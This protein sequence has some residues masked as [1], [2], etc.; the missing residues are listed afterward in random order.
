MNAAPP[1]APIEAWFASRGWTPMD[2]QRQCWQ[3][4]LDGPGS[5][6]LGGSL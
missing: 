1:L 6:S 3:A 4:Y 5:I 2:F